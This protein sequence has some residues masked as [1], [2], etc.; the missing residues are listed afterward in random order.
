M[1]LTTP[2]SMAPS[3]TANKSQAATSRRSRRPS[4]PRAAC[5]VRS[6]I[7]C[8]RRV[9]TRGPPR[10]GDGFAERRRGVCPHPA[11][12]LLNIGDEGVLVDLV[13]PE[14]RVLPVLLG[15]RDVRR[16]TAEI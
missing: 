15:H 2:P 11:H 3:E 9:E 12:R 8:A 4:S 16:K 14:F 10:L 1:T 6:V 5:R 13:V 7:G